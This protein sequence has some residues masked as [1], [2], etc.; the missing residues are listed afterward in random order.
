MQEHVDGQFRDQLR[1]R[2]A[3]A[4]KA[5][6]PTAELFKQQVTGEIELTDR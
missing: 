1:E 3:R 5:P 2:K 4:R 6:A